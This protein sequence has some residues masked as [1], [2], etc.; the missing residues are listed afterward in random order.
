MMRFIR[1]GF[2]TRIVLILVFSLVALQIL[3]VMGFYLRRSGDTGAGFRLPLPDQVAAIVALV[4]H[5]P[6]SDRG[7]ILRAVNSPH[8]RVWVTKENPA[9]PR[10]TWHKL[11]LV[12]QIVDNYLRALGAHTVTVLLQTKIKR[13]VEKPFRSGLVTVIVTLEDGEHLAFESQGWFIT[14]VFGL[15]PGFWAGVFG[16]GIALLAI[17]IISREARPLRQ[18]VEA[19]D[20]I[21]LSAPKPIADFPSSAPEIRALIAAFNRMQERIASLIKERMAMIGGFSHD[22]RTYATRL[23]LRMELI[24]DDAERA[25][26]IRDIEDMISLVNDALLAVQDPAESTQ[27]EQTTLELIDITELVGDEIDDHRKIGTSVT[28]VCEGAKGNAL[29]LGQPVALR[30]LFRNLIENAITY[31]GEARVMVQMR[32]EHVLVHIEDSGPGIPPEARAN[33][34]QAFVRLETSRSRRTG[35]AGLGLTIAQKIAESHGGTLEIGDAKNGGARVSVTLPRFQSAGN[36]YEDE[37]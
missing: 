22:L 8:L 37:D 30:R 9:P 25:R 29:V 33:V 5:T 13:L 34:T 3:V 35:G 17:L 14:D 2:V 24:A 10:E 36:Q 20:S 19:A 23:R 15:P 4:E 12:E 27:R 31:G 1:F 28:L 18:L 16:F 32:A 7:T 11:P 6:E 21:D 26:A